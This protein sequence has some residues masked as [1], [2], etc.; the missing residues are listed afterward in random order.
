[1]P[2]FKKS[3]P[4]RLKSG[5]KPLFKTTSSSPIKKA[6]PFDPRIHHHGDTSILPP[7]YD[8][9]SAKQDQAIFNMYKS[10]RI[11]S[12]ELKLME[13]HH[14][15]AQLALKRLRMFNTLSPKEQTRRTQLRDI[16]TK[17]IPGTDT[18]LEDVI[19]GPKM[20]WVRDENALKPKYGKGKRDWAYKRVP[21]EYHKLMAE[22]GHVWDDKTGEYLGLKSKINRR[23]IK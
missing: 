7:T 10:N 8:A 12:G 2:K 20:E 19:Y 17:E 3:T 23:D 9:E 1:M 18:T 13:E 22:K 16:T 15:E 11:E 6:D 21:T 5:N 4:F 14:P